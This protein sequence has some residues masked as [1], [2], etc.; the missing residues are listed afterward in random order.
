M[1]AYNCHLGGRKRIICN[2]S[3]NYVVVAT[4]IYEEN[5]D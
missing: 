1:A 3:S 5:G 2:I 4:A